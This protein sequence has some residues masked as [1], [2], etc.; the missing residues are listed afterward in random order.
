ML[1]ADDIR[2]ETSGKLLIVGLY[3]QDIV[4]PLEQFIVPQ[5]AILFAMEG[6]QT[7]RHPNISFAVSFPGEEEKTIDVPLNWPDKPIS[8]MPPDRLR[9][10]FKYYTYVGAITLREGPISATVL[11]GDAKILLTP[12]HIRYV[13]PDDKATEEATS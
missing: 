10:K 13:P 3:T 6:A 9:W 11:Y 4:I 1:V 7:E 5:L 12:C 2:S 8:D